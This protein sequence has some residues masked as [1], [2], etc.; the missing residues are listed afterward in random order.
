MEQVLINMAE[1]ASQDYRFVAASIQRYREKEGLSW[2]EIAGQLGIDRLALARIALCR[3]PRPTHFLEDSQKIAGYA[4][5]DPEILSKF[6]LPGARKGPKVERIKIGGRDMHASKRY[7]AWAFGIIA[8]MVL[9]LGAL[10]YSRPDHSSATL[11]VSEGQATVQQAS[12]FLRIS[13]ANGLLVSPGQ[14]VTL[15]AGDAIS[16]GPGSAAQL[17]LYDGSSVDLSEN[18]TIQ[19]TALDTSQEVYVV[20]INLLSGKLLN[21][22]L[23]LLDVGDAFEIKTPSSTV[24]VRGTVFSVAVITPQTTYVA[25]EKGVVQVLTDGNVVQVKAGEEIYST[26]GQPPQIKPTQTVI[27][28]NVQVDVQPTSSASVNDPTG[29]TVTPSLNIATGATSAPPDAVATAESEWWNSTTNQ[30][31]DTTDASPPIS[32]TDEVTINSPGAHPTEVPGKPP[33]DVPG[34]PPTG[35]AEPPGHGGSPPGL[36][37]ESPPGLGGSPPGQNK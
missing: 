16:V 30:G 9:I 7:F 25:C 11:V 17:R 6:L 3:R 20:R 18:T 36:G 26:S 37:G 10:V 4:G 14:A 32:S 35:G 1:R 21:R 23:R 33:D 12:P 31:G 34:D 27:Q 28:N 29:S 24:T 13:S 8:L 2:D 15:K 22:V 19:I 5:V